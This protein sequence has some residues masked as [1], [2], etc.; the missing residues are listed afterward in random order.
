MRVAIVEDDGAQAACVK[1]IIARWDEAAIIV[2]YESAEAL[3]FDENRAFDVFILDIQMP[4]MDGMSLAK[5]LR[6]RGEDAQMIFTTAFPDY[7]ADGYDVNAVNYLVKPVSDERL[8]RALNRAKERLSRAR[9]TLVMDGERF[10]VDEI[11]FCEAKGRNVEIHM[12][13][14]TRS[15]R[16]TVNALA[17]LLGPG[18]FRCQRSFIAGLAHVR[19]VTRAALEM[20]DNTRVPLSR[21]LYD[22]ANRAF[23]D[24][25]WR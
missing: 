20:D 8:V 14:G 2:I 7:M 11:V 15:V 21:K 4:G 19:R 13:G 23:I 1:A 6:A 22:T 16:I 5:T 24:H 25:N 18:F 12:I 9:R 17:E 3:L 10:F